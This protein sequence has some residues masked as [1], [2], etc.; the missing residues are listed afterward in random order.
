MG[1]KVEY[2]RP[3]SLS[4]ALALLGA[5][6]KDLKV[7]AG[8]TNLLVQ[9]KD[10]TIRPKIFMDIKGLSELSVLSKKGNG[11]TQIGPSITMND[12][13]AWCF[14]QGCFR[15]LRSAAGQLGS[16][17]IRNRA[18]VGGNLC[19]ASPAAD[20]AVAL[21]TYDATVVLK[22]QHRERTVTL[23]DFFMG[24]HTADLT[25]AELVTE[26]RI[27]PIPF[28]VG[29]SFQK[30]GHRKAVQIAIVGAA[31]SIIPENPS[32]MKMR[33]ARIALSSVAPKPMRA[34]KAEEML[35][36]QGWAEDLL[37]QVAEV[38][39]EE[40]SPITDIRASRE[41]RRAMIPVLVKRAL[42][43]AWEDLAKKKERIK[44]F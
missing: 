8:G 12:L 39:A 18:T 4:E 32:S 27:P 20:T 16:A 38:A 6:G 11:E 34:R 37:K 10:G 22:S 9:L 24:P 33:Q 41:Y 7:L 13:V 21:L 26:I 5:Y 23:H 43:E 2:R 3:G 44:R 25:P 15:N 40:A 17:M 36:G 14:S 30:L 29:E 19:D 35:I 42:C 1:E 28:S 31:V